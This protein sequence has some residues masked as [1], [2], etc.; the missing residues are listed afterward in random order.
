MNEISLRKFAATVRPGGPI[1][2]NSPDVADKLGSARVANV[3]LL[4]ALLR[5]TGCLDRQTA[6][7]IVQR[8]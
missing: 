8:Q 3:A 1:L 5:V 2:Y 6:F 4:A 7:K